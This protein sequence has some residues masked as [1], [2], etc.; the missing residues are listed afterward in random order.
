MRVGRFEVEEHASA[1][2]A[3]YLEEEAEPFGALRIRIAAAETNRERL[4]AEEKSPGGCMYDNM[5]YS[6]DIKSY[7]ASRCRDRPSPEPS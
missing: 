2:R 7:G 6:D 3:P 5:S 1:M 4:R